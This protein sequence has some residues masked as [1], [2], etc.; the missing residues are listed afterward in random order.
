MITKLIVAPVEEPV[1][2]AEAQAQCRTDD[3]SD[4]DL[5]RGLISAAREQAEHEISRPMWL[6]HCKASARSTRKQSR[7]SSSQQHNG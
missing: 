1:T 4:D 3:P 2:L 5:I 6:T 7:L